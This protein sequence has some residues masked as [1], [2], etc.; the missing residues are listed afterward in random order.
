LHYNAPLFLRGRLVVTIYDLTHILDSSFRRTLKS[1]VYAQPMLRSVASKAD[2]IFTISMYSS[3][4]I[5]EVLHVNPEKISVTYPGVSSEFRRLD[6]LQC[7]LRVSE[8]LGVNS[9]FLLFVGNLKSHK[10]FLG[11]LS[12]FAILRK[13]GRIESSLVVVGDDAKGGLE[14]RARIQQL[15]LEDHVVVV[16]RVAKSLLVDLYNS[17]DLLVLPSF[18]EGF[19][20]P[21]LES[22]AC[23]TPVACARTASLP[24]V[25]G[26]LAEYF[27]PYEYEDIADAI[28]RALCQKH[29]E[30]IRLEGPMWSAQFGW[31][32]CVDDVFG[33]YERLV[34]G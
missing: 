28:E 26:G 16:P 12:A 22:L 32:S 15:S 27:D 29:R 13:S 2:H 10:N 5:S 24:E 31:G 25:G 34:L 23:G 19:G 11:L 3:K 17:A 33:T 14:L 21:V 8:A 6:R 9:P 7:T 1:W 30:R 20:L 18:E 4:C